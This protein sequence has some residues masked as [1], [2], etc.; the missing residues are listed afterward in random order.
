MKLNDY[1]QAVKRT[2]PELS[3]HYPDLNELHMVMGISTEANE[4]LDVYKKN[5][6]YKKPIDEVNIKEEIG[7]LLWYLGNY[8]NIKG[9]DLEEI[10]ETN[11]NKL[12]KRYPEK[13]TEENAI[14]RNLKEE[15]L[16]LE[17]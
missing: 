3:N 12:K 5:L 16:I 13:F 1:L 10:M 9:Y 11:I 6:A 2:N 14:N 4:L 15:R 8:C 7:D 17:Q